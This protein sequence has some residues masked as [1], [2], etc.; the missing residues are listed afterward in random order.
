MFS[1]SHSHLTKFSCFNCT[2]FFSC[3]IFIITA[4]ALHHLTCRV[5]CGNQRQCV[6]VLWWNPTCDCLHSPPLLLLLCIG[7]SSSAVFLYIPSS[8]YLSS[9]HPS[10]HPFIHLPVQLLDQ[11]D[12]CCVRS[13]L[14]CGGAQTWAQSIPPPRDP[15]FSLHPSSHCQ[16]RP[17]R[18]SPTWMYFPYC[19]FL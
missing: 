16:S 13:P 12:F 7:L 15:L 2:H 18:Q 19:L 14:M 4:Q 5:Y 10:V 17:L 9:V 3:H 1:N 8:G 11:Q 6:S